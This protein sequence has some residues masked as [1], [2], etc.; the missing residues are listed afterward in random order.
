MLGSP[1]DLFENCP[2]FLWASL[3]DRR[4]AGRSRAGAG[5]IG[6]GGRVGGSGGRGRS[7]PSQAER[8]AFVALRTDSTPVRSTRAQLR[9]PTGL[10]GTA[11]PAIPQPLCRGAASKTV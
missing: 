4:S 3:W 8:A 11:R 7:A 5:E 10:P 6:V 2:K 9:S 1:P